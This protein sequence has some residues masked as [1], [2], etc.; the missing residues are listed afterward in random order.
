MRNIF[1][2][3]NFPS[4][5]PFHFPLLARRLLLFP[6]FSFF[7]SATFTFFAMQNRAGK[8]GGGGK[9]DE[10][11]SFKPFRPLTPFHKNYCHEPAKKKK[12][13]RVAC[14]SRRKLG[15]LRNCG[16]RAGHVSAPLKFKFF[17]PAL[18]YVG[19]WG[20]ILIFEQ[21]V[22]THTHTLYLQYTLPTAL[23]MYQY[24][25]NVNISSSL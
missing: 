25:K 24:S 3:C 4:S 1:G 13:E 7:L 22:H 16:G 11:L 5:P 23:T 15:N 12:G 8:R 19:K 20:N 9:K 6:F 21:I 17:F 2:P 10:V 14:L 18:Q